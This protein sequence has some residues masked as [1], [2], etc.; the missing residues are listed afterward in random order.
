MGRRCGR[1]K[2]AKREALSGAF[3]LQS[4]RGRCYGY[5]LPG[6]S[7]LLPE[8]QQLKRQRTP[9]R[10]GLPFLQLVIISIQ[11]LVRQGEPLRYVCN[12]GGIFVSALR[13]KLNDFY[14]TRQ[15]SR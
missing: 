5:P 12:V 6:S 7:N 3:K 4:Q 14:R 15:A 2:A 9:L 8:R 11:S 13:L 1:A 10:T